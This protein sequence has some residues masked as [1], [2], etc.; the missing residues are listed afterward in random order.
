MAF[1][2]E[3]DETL[4]LKLQSLEVGMIP[5]MAYTSELQKVENCFTDAN[6]SSLVF[7]RADCDY[8]N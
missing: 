4:I 7:L 6:Q 5:V 2:Q 1:N 3:F 8:K